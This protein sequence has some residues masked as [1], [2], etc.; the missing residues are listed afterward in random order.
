MIIIYT[1]ESGATIPRLWALSFW[2]VLKWKN[3]AAVD[4]NGRCLTQRPFF[5]EKIFP[6]FSYGSAPPVTGLDRSTVPHRILLSGP[7]FRLGKSSGN[8]PADRRPGHPG[9]GFPRDRLR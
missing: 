5:H 1:K 7:E 3:P 6:G 9:P 2:P 8:H 4:E